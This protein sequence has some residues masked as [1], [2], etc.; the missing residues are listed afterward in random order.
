MSAMVQRLN[1]LAYLAV[2]CAVA[3]GVVLFLF[4][5]RKVLIYALLAFLLLYC[6]GLTLIGHVAK[7]IF[8]A[9]N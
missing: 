9:G 2:P 1:E 4:G 7:W 3:I 6:G 5:Q 8:G